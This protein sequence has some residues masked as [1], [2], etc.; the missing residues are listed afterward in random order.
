MAVQQ[1]AAAVQLLHRSLAVAHLRAE[2]S[3]PRC[4]FWGQ[5]VCVCG[6]GLVVPRV[7]C[8]VV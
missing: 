1:H 7:R 8:A 4:G 2:A 6:V 5:C 3:K